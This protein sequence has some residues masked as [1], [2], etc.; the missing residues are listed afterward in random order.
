[1]AYSEAF[2]RRMVAR[3]CGPSPES[4]CSLARETG[5][6]QQS[7]SRW[8]RLAGAVS[9]MATPSDQEGLGTTHPN[10]PQPKKDDW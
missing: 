4:A 5:V 9:G 3:M 7:L 8:L 10:A 2:R 6:C 1:M